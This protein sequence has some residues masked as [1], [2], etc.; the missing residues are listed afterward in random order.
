MSERRP[1]APS[2][3]RNPDLDTWIRIE[4]DGSVTVFT[5]KVE[6]GQG[7]RSA[8]A[9]IAAEELDVEL[10]QVRVHTA[11]TAEG[12]DEFLTAGSMSVEHSGSAVR[13]AAAEARQVLLEAAA[14]RLSASLA[15]LVVEAGVVRVRGAATGV[16]YG[17]LFGDRRFERKITG[18]GSAKPPGSYR[19][20]GKP[21]PRIDLEAKLTGGAFL[22]DLHPPGMLFGRVVRPPGPAA[23]LASVDLE[24]VRSL[25]GVVAVVRDGSFL[26]LV[27]EREEQAVW[28][29]ERLRD[30]ATWSETPSL[31]AGRD[32]VDWMLEQPRESYAVVAGT[33]EDRAP[34]PHA[35]PA[36]A[37]VSLG[38]RYARPYLMHASIGPSAALAELRDGRLTVWTHSQGIGFARDAIAQ[39]LEMPR[40]AVRLV[41]A[42]GAGCYGHN[43]ADDAALDA[44]LLARAVPGRPVMLQW[45]RDDEHCF[46]PYGP[47]MVVD[48]HGSLDASGNVID[49]SHEVLS[50]THVGRPIPGQAGSRLLAAWHLDPPH[51]RPAPKPRFG[52]EV[53]IHRN[54]WPGYA[55]ARTRVVKHLIRSEPLRT[56]SLRG[57]GAFANVF[58]IESFMDELAHAARVDPLDFRL[59]HLEDERARAVLQAAAEAAGW[60]GVKAGGR[61]LGLAYGRYTNSKAYAAV[62]VDLEVEDSGAIRLHRA[63]LAADA[64]QVIDPQ[65]L[66]NQLEGGFVQAASWTLFEE[67]RFDSTRVTSR[68]WD[69]YPILGFADVPDV[70]TVLLDRPEDRPLGAGEATQG[71]TPAAIANAVFRATGRRLRRTP[72]GPERVRA[73][74]GGAASG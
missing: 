30:A 37:A 40:D 35:P 28:A 42:D 31:P 65:G 49:W 19:I 8:I 14:E 21:G 25:R 7:L 70:E 62:V 48:L 68:D 45:M 2:L 54:A 59:R 18:E 11:D 26:G 5:G 60:P 64:G 3:A 61:A 47:A 13:L 29:R 56:S 6:I 23:R 24:S 36:N 73:S 67:V 17:E 32:L 10:S 57:L 55:F 1:P 39:V 51:E 58:A 52:P 27:A 66:A 72:F 44:A 43:G 63:V 41:H 69:G 9:R 53:G 22:H 16:S 12:P 46:E 15:Q 50:Q 74:A 34:E 20:V 4:R 38:A 71:P 33:A